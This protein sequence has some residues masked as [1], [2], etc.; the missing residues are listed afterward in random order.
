[1]SDYVYFL[2][3]EV[4]PKPDHSHKKRTFLSISY[5][6]DLTQIFTDIADIYFLSELEFN[7]CGFIFLLLL[8]T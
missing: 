5:D 2:T 3:K 6:Y 4:N 1:M 7:L 8:F